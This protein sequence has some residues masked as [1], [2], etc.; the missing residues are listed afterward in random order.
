MR[1]HILECLFHVNEIYL[2]HVI[3]LVE[4]K[5]GP[6]MMQDGA[7][8]NKI[9]NI[10]KSELQEISNPFPKVSVT[11]LAAIHL[12]SK[13]E[14]FFEQKGKI[15]SETENFRSDQLCLLVLAC[16]TFMTIP[17]NLT[18]LLSYKK[19]AISHSR[20]ITTA[21]GYLRLL[22]FKSEQLSKE[23]KKKLTR[24]V[25][26]LVS[27]YVPSLII[28][29]LKPE[30]YDGPFLTLFQRDLLLAFNKIDEEMVTLV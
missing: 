22:L 5:K 9:K 15:S 3:S 21:N 20:W 16:S 23:D 17:N 26:Y 29:H 30:A 6:G 14:W 28:T 13:I 27:V 25:S 8:L 18:N 19:E 12:K 11:G 7:L 4:G 1:I 2:S 24:I 10:K